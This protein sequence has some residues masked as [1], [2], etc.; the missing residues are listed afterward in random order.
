MRRT[1]ILDAWW[2]MARQRPLCWHC[3]DDEGAVG[4]ATAAAVAALPHPGMQDLLRDAGRAE[5]ERDPPH[6][7]DEVAPLAKK[8][9]RAAQD[10]DGSGD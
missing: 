10:D 4:E 1:S 7:V 8:E 2:D 3:N 5:S 6:E 9:L